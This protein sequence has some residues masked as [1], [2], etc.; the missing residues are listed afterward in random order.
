MLQVVELCYTNTN[1]DVVVLH[2]EKLWYQG[3]HSDGRMAL[4]WLET[5]AGIHRILHL[6]DELVEASVQGTEEL[7]F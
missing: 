3:L 7:A 1:V 2:D 4:P 6:D 5:E